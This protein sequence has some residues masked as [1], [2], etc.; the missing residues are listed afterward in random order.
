MT[1]VF[2][3]L[4]KTSLAFLSYSRVHCHL[5]RKED[6]AFEKIKKELQYHAAG[7]K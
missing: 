7:R 3:G 6:E 5:N 1:V 2:P 4:N